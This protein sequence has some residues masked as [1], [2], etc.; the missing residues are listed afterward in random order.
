MEFSSALGL[1]LH[2]TT[3]IFSA[4][5]VFSQ[6]LPENIVMLALFCNILLKFPST[7]FAVRC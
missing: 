1:K 7:L 5:L 2:I 4:V 3:V 6:F